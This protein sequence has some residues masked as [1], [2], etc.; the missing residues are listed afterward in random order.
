MIAHKVKDK[1][2]PNDKLVLSLKTD[3]AIFTVCHHHGLS[4]LHRMRTKQKDDGLT[5]SSLPE[6]EEPP[7]CS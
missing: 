4:R 1:Q 6:K 5:Q 7:Y 2:F 3:K